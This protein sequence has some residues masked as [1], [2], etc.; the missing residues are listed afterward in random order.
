VVN[1]LG[2][3][4]YGIVYKCLH[5]PSGINYAV[6]LIM[7]PFKYEHTG[8]QLYREIKILDALSHMSNNSYTP[9]I[10][11]IILPP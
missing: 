9:T 3:G 8:R 10:Y 5:I 11:D 2:E 4:S 1:K 7:K 6:K